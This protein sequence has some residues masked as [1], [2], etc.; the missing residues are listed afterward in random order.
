MEV[1]KKLYWESKDFDDMAW[2]DCKLYGMAFNDLKH[3][4]YLDIDYILQWINR[5]KENDFMFYVA[6]ATFV[7]SRV[8]DLQ[9]SIFSLDFV[10]DEVLQNNPKIVSVRGSEN[11]FLE[12]EWSISLTKGE[13]NFKSIGFEMFLRKLPNL[14]FQMYKLICKDSRHKDGK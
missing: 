12:Y 11:S 5:P 3:D 7:F 8:H 2:H 4:L 6:P 1:L 13:I 9:C 14:I 10:I